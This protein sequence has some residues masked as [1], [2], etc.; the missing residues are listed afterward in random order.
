MNKSTPI[1][2]S[3]IAGRILT[4]KQNIPHHREDLGPKG[5]TVLKIGYNVTGYFPN[6]RM[7]RSGLNTKL[8]NNRPLINE[9]GVN[10]R[11]TILQRIF[12]KAS[13]D[14]KNVFHKYQK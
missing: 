3:P 8:I 11:A 10:P 7:R 14:W 1:F 5:D 12:N 9:R 6:R 4:E 2:H 13:K